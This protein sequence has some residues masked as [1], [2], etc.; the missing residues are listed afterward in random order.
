[1]SRPTTVKPTQKPVKSYYEALAKY[2]DQ[3]V[4]HE[5]AVRSAFQNLLDD[6]GRRFGWTLVPELSA[7]LRGIGRPRPST[8]ETPVP[9]AVDR[10]S[11]RV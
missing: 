1:M 4:D 11:R 2:A 9:P 10:G 7:R 8:G 5:G 3:K 6:V